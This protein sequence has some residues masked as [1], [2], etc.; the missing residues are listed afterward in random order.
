MILQH[1]V[2]L[3]QICE[4]ERGDVNLDGTIDVKDAILVLRHIVGL[5]EDFTYLSLPRGSFFI[6]GGSGKY[7]LDDKG[8]P[9]DKE[10]NS[11]PTQ[12][13]QYGLDLYA[14]YLNTGAPVYKQKLKP[15]I[16]WILDNAVQ[17]SSFCCWEFDFDYKPFNQVAPWKSS[18]TNAQCALTLLLGHEIFG[19]QECLDL[20]HQ[21][22]NY[23]FIP[24]EN[25]G[26]M[27]RWP[28]GTIWFEE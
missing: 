20:S 15:V 27:G 2:G 18:L 6:N 12:T 14:D 28:D 10:G 3:I 4:P 11:H 26:G 5:I 23:L 16:E 21:A 7:N 13:A 17:D 25:G 19:D 8:I 9:V 24:V 1:N 22:M